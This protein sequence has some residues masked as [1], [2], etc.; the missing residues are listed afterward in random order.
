MKTA[1]FSNGYTDVYKGNRDVKA[2]WAVIEIATGKVVDSGHSLTKAA[3][4]KT[5]RTSI[6]RA[7]ML[8]TG[9]REYKN[10]PA[11]IRCAKA[12]GFNRPGDMEREYK[13]LNA[14]KAAQYKI[15]VVSL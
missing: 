3:A 5:A 6:P 2:A 8:P 9:W 10:T 15:E 12:S 1:I 14:E 4:E 13:R 7:R 11:G